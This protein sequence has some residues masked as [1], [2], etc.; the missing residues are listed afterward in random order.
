MLDYTA[1]PVGKLL[2]ATMRQLLRDLNDAS[3]PTDKE[4][5]AGAVAH[6]QKAIKDGL[7]QGG[8]GSALTAAAEALLDQL[9]NEQEPTK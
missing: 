3:D 6:L 7:S 4:K 2:E 1:A 9:H 8:E 5:L